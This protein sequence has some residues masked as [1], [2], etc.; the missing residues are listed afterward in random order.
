M[1]SKHQ[2]FQNSLRC[3]QHSATW[4]CIALLFVNDHILKTVY[5]SWITGKLSDFAGLFFFPFILAAGLCFPLSKFRISTTRVGQ[6]AFGLSGI[7]FILLKTVPLANS[8]TIGLASML[9]GFPT[10]LVIDPTDLIA[11]LAMFPA[12]VIWSQ[13]VS[14]KPTSAAYIALLFGSLAVLATSPK[15]PT[16]Y[17]VTNLE[18][19]Q[20]GIIYAAD[21]DDWGER[22]Y[23]VAESVDG[24]ATWQ[25]SQEVEN[26]EEKGLPIKNCGRLNPAI[27]YQ[28]TKSGRLQELTA[29]S[30]WVSVQGIKTKGYDLI[31]F[32]WNDREYVIVAIG[33]YGIL[34]RELP[35]GKWETIQVLQADT[36]IP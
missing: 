13:P 19:Y 9:L 15:Y 25:E 29:E 32:E 6:I 34:R 11:L 33:E 18:Y 4:L 7:W 2:S 28:V 17:K 31:L 3:L 14:F 10:K 24:G 30:E 21:T 27:C 8:L 35:D 36:P 26:I 20:D 16:V 1:S 5:P 12:W 23:P 22:Y